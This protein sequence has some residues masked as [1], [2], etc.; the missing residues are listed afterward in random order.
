MLKP[1]Y[2]LVHERGILVQIPVRVIEMGVS[3]I[4][5]QRWQTAL[6]VCARAIA[7]PQDLDDHGVP[8]I[9]QTRPRRIRDAAQS[10]FPRQSAE[11]QA[12]GRVRNPAAKQRDTAGRCVLPKTHCAAP[13]GACRRVHRDQLGFPELRVA[14]GQDTLVEIDVRQIKVQCLADTHPGDS[15]QAEDRIARP[16]RDRLGSPPSLQTG[17]EKAGDLLVAGD[18]RLEG[19]SLPRQQI[20]WRNL[21]VR[22]CHDAIAQQNCGRRAAFR[23]DNSDQSIQAAAP[24]PEPRST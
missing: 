8:H 6:G 11:R 2:R 9:V 10:E 13:S 21:G 19:T 5:G 18:M 7:L 20:R 3:Q 23:Q 4:S 17:G 1:R 14:Y 22:V 15:Q 12:Q 16:A 24:M